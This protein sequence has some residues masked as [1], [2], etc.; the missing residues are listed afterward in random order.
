MTHWNGMFF[1]MRYSY[2]LM[3]FPLPRFSWPTPLPE[4]AGRSGST[5]AFAF[6][7]ASRS[8]CLTGTINQVASPAR[9]FFVMINLVRAET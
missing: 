4:F 2:G 3:L 5:G 7:C 9:P 6:L 8:L 1:P